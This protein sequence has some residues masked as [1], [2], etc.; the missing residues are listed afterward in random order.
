MAMSTNASRLVPLALAAVLLLPLDSALAQ[1]PPAP[2]PGPQPAGPPPPQDE[3]T[4]PETDAPPAE[5]P[6]DDGP[7]PAGIGT[8]PQPTEVA[9]P[10]R[11][12]MQG[13]FGGAQPRGSRG[14]SLDLT[15]SAFAGWDEPDSIPVVNPLNDRVA[16]SGGFAGGAGT[17][18]YTKP[19]RRVNLS[20]YGSGFVGYFPDNDDPWYPSSSAGFAGDVTFDVGSRSSLR[21]AQLEGWSTDLALGRL[22]GLGGMGQVPSAGG[23]TAFDNSLERSPSL[24]S[25][26]SANFQYE[27]TSRSSLNLFYGYRNAHFFESDPLETFPSRNDHQAG[28]RFERRFTMDLSLHA[29]YTYRKSWTDGDVEDP[30]AFH[31]IDLGVGYSKSLPLSRRTQL[32]FSTG[33]TIAASESGDPDGGTFNDTRFFVVGTAGLIHEIGRS[34]NAQINYSRDVGYEDGFAD[35]FLRDSAVARIGGFLN[36]RVDVSAQAMWTSAAIG[37]GERNYSSWN[38]TAQVRTAI[39]QNLAAYAYY[40]YYLQDFAQDV[41]LPPGVVPDLNRHGVRVGLT[42]WLPLWSAR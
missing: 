15:M 29:G 11:A 9:M 36:P 38:A 37:L 20:G 24:T 27:M 8:S 41:S 10:T 26:S 13:L 7:R 28:I 35:P 22:N 30:V 12:R 16:L 4:P 5:E 39:T 23:D 2:P 3:E 33:S 1:Q 40:Y 17:L 34:W 31:D 19:G 14:Q 21:L 18:F 32:T 42:T 6:V 25:A